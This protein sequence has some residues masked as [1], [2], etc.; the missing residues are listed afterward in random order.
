MKAIPKR[1]SGRYF[2]TTSI[3]IAAGRAISNQD[4]AT[5]LEVVSI[6]DALAHRFFAKGD[7]IGRSVS[8]DHDEVAGQWQILGIARDTKVSGPRSTEVRPLIYVPLTSHS[9]KFPPL[10]ALHGG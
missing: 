7:A 3:P 9:I 10:V 4:S 1:V 5:S 6:N 2:E 8:I